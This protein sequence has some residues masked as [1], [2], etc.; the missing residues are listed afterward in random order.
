[1]NLRNFKKT[2]LLAAVAA[3]VSMSSFADIDMDAAGDES[4][5]YATELQG[6]LTAGKVAI[7][8][9]AQITDIQGTADF[10]ATGATT[11]YIRFDLT[12]ATFDGNPASFKQKSKSDDSVVVT[13][14]L[15]NGGDGESYAIYKQ[16]SEQ[17]ITAGQQWDLV[18]GT[19]YKVDPTATVTVTYAQYESA[20]NAANQTSALMSKSK[21]AFKFV[22]GADYTAIIEASPVVATVASNFQK[23]NNAAN[24][25]SAADSSGLTALAFLDL[26]DVI[27][28]TPPLKLDGNASAKEDYITQ[29]QTITVTGDVSLGEFSSNTQ[30]TCG[31]GGTKIVCT[32]NTAKTACTITATDA[33]NDAYIC[34]DMSGLTAGQA[35]SK[36]DYSIAYEDEAV[37][38]AA[39]SISYDTVTVEVPYVTTYEG[40][41]QRIF[42]DNRGTTAAGYSTTFTS[43]NG[44][45]ATAGT[46]ASGTL[47]AGEM[48]TVKVT[49]LVTFT[50]GSR[51]SATM[52]VEA[53]TTKLQVTTQIVDLGTGMTDTLVLHP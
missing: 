1:M 32:P 21:E 27:S 39:G 28:A 2:T 20:T 53:G 15:E 48:A 38:G 10:A 41:N 49:D 5:K 7:V 52:E 18:I 46:A 31:A 8:K 19:G 17:N 50:G 16:V 45:T 42:I 43:E 33:D 51:G 47:A 25:S 12:N 34:V 40:Y 29:A 3:S 30:Q 9:N 36:G 4:L 11:R 23:F 6:T 13:G 26:G 24:I 22:S 37:S 14:V 35:V 44:V